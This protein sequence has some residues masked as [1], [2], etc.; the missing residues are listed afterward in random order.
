MQQIRTYQGFTPEIGK[1]CFIDASS[2]IIGRVKVGSDSSIWCNSVVRGDVSS[3]E[4][5][6]NTNIQDLT[7]L[8]VTHYSPGISAESPLRIGDNVTIGH[9]C[10]LHACTVMDNVLVGMGSTLLDNC[11]VES[12]VFIGAGSVVPPNKRLESGYLYFGNP[13]KQIRPL[14]AA[15]IQFIQYSAEHYV[16]VKNAY[17]ESE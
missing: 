10:C 4:I 2:V 5:G 6:K 15:E 16:R 13:L 12:N 3:I 17:L 11:I 8:H 1:N 7:M 14:S 9:N